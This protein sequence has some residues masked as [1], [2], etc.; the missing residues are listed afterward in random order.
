[1]V[2]N[3]AIDA[4]VGSVPLFGDVFDAAWQA[5]IRNVRIYREALRQERSR[6]V[7]SLFVA[8]VILAFVLMLAIPVVVVVLVAKR[9]FSP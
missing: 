2:A 7:D 9:L 6:T 5:N 8:G 3:V 4:V 1:M